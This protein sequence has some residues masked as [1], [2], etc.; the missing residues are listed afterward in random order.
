M[1]LLELWWIHLLLTQLKGT[2]TWFLINQYKVL[3]VQQNTKFCGMTTIYLKISY[4]SLLTSYATCLVVVPELCH[5]LL[6][7]T[8]LILLPIEAGF[9]L[10]AKRYS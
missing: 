7:P 2:F 9:I 1:C 10:R 6:P 3:H 4:K 8:M 5:I